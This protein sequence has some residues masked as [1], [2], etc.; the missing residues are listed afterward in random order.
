MQNLKVA[1]QL[2][3]LDKCTRPV[4]ISKWCEA[5]VLRSLA[6]SSANRKRNK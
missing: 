3:Q 6:N 4:S 2:P 5:K 1:G